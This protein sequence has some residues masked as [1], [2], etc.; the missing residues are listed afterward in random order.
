VAVI[1]DVMARRFWPGAS[2]IGKRLKM[3]LRSDKDSFEIV[4]VVGSTRHNSLADPPEPEIYA[5]LDQVSNSGMVVV[6]RAEGDLWKLAELIQRRVYQIDRDQPVFRTFTLAD[7]VRQSGTQ[8]RFYMVLFAVFAVVG[9]SLS[10]VGLYGVMAHSV[11]RRLH[12]ISVRIAVGAKGGDVL[13]MVVGE[14]LKLSLLGVALGMLVAYG[15]VR[16]L[17]SLLYDIGA[18]D[19]LTFSVVPLIVVS[20]A[21]LASYL[22]AQRALRVD[23]VEALREG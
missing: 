3:G 2:P 5:P 13:R 14:G 16:F 8:T 23:P 22:P 7:L 17:S 10:T 9:L 19:P 4:G 11:S 15:L 6:A 20:V 21:I 12:E 1:N 18:R